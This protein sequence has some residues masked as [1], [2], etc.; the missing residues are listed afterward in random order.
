LLDAVETIFFV[1]PRTRRP[2]VCE[3][4]RASWQT[5]LRR[6]SYHE[7]SL[8]QK[9]SSGSRPPDPQRPPVPQRPPAHM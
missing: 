2:H 7:I 9:L 5:H 6:Q 4:A 1:E 8:L 3:S